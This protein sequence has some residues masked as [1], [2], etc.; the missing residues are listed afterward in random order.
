MRRLALRR[1]LFVGL[2]PALCAACAAVDSGAPAPVPAPAPA[3]GAQAQPAVVEVENIIT[4]LS[5]GTSR[6]V[7]EYE[8]PTGTRIPDVVCKSLQNPSAERS[9]AQHTGLR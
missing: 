9:D 4:P 3:P 2:A 5:D 1:L 7:C 6:Y 8:T